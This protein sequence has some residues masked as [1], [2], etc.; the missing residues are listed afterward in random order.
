MKNKIEQLKSMRDEVRQ[1]SKKWGDA[2]MLA[3]DIKGREHETHELGMYKYYSAKLD[4]F[5]EVINL[6][7]SE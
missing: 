1:G 4:C 2:Y 5:N 6:L 7:E 3:K